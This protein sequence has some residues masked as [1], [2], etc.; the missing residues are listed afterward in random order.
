PVEFYYKDRAGQRVNH[1]IVEVLIDG[2]W[3][4]ID[5]TY[6]AYWI[7]GTPTATFA[8]RTLQ[9]VLDRSDPRTKI[10]RS[11]SLI[12][13]GLHDQIA[14][15][16]LFDYLTSDGDVL[17]G[18][19]GEI[20]LSLHGNEGIE[21][22]DNIPNFIGDNVLDENAGGV[23]YRLEGD[24]L[25]YH[26]TINIAGSAAISDKPICI[27]LDAACQKLSTDRGKYE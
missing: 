27:C 6:G 20:R 9:Q 23:S 14:G 1:I 5:T 19:E 22:F 24:F 7:D 16:D 11:R 15:L 13:Y 18:G 12:P 8:M 21:T 2:D 25:P 26:I 17:R 3:R 4:P 10:I